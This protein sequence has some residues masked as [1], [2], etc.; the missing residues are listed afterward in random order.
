MFSVET[1]RVSRFCSSLCLKLDFQHE[2]HRR[3]NSSGKRD[4]EEPKKYAATPLSKFELSEA[5]RLHHFLQTQGF[6]KLPCLLTASSAHQKLFMKLKIIYLCLDFADTTDDRKIIQFCFTNEG[7]KETFRAA[8]QTSPWA[9]A[10][11]VLYVTAEY[12]GVYSSECN[13]RVQDVYR[14]PFHKKAKVAEPDSVLVMQQAVREL[15]TE[16]EP[17]VKAALTAKWEPIIAFDLLQRSQSDLDRKKIE[18]EGRLKDIQVAQALNLFPPNQE[19]LAN[20]MKDDDM[21]IL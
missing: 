3:V 13:L 21:N 2:E 14:S 20:I 17:R 1:N 4:R 7:K 5:D 8:F 10:E 19:E 9:L 16:M 12:F 18:V 11:S 6:S 15:K